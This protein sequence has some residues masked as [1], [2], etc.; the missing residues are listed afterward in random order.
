MPLNLTRRSLI[1]SAFATVALPILPLRTETARAIHVVKGAG[2]ECCSAWVDHLKAAGFLVTEEEM[3]GTLL[4]RF[5]LD[6][7][8]P[9][10]MLSCHTG[11]IAGYSIEG[12]VPAA[13]INRLLDDAPDAIGLTVPGMPYGS[14]GMGD[15]DDRE[16][17]DVF[18]IKPDG[19]TEVF[20]TYPAA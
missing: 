6:N 5:K 4:I 19:T 18:L 15:E 3:Y 9:Q 12:H 1:T 14:P 10:R 16:A 11:R 13:D 7:G 8:V 20:T 17:Y 2:C